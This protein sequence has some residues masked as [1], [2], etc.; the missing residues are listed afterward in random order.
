MNQTDSLDNP[1]NPVE[2]KGVPLSVLITAGRPYFLK[3]AS[4]TGLDP[5]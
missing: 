3:I 2:A 4:K 5:L 1:P